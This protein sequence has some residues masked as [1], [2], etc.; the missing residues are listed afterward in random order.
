M[1]DDVPS[2]RERSSDSKPLCIDVTKQTVATPS[3][4]PMIV[5]HVDTETKNRPDP[6]YRRAM[7]DSNDILYPCGRMQPPLFIRIVTR[8]HASSNQNQTV[9]L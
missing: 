8:S 6:K 7:N 5:I 1:C 2:R 4:T 9:T 3:V